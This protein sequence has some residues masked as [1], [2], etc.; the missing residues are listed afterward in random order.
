MPGKARGTRGMPAA[1]ALH[2]RQPAGGWQ[3][4]G[5]PPSLPAGHCQPR[6]GHRRAASWARDQA[7]ARAVQ[8]ARCQ[9]PTVPGPGSHGRRQS[10][11]PACA[12]A[13]GGGD[14]ART[15]DTGRWGAGGARRSAGRAASGCHNK[16]PLCGHP[17]RETK[18]QGKLLSLLCSFS[19]AGRSPALSQPHRLHTKEGLL[20]E[21]GPPWHAGGHPLHCRSH[22]QHGWGAWGRLPAQRCSPPV[23]APLPAPRT[24]R[25]VGGVPCPGC[26][27][28][29]PLPREGLAAEPGGNRARAASTGLP[30]PRRLNP[31]PAGPRRCCP[32]GRSGGPMRPCP[33]A[34]SL[35]QLQ[36]LPLPCGPLPEHPARFAAHSQL[37]RWP[38]KSQ[39]SPPQ[40]TTPGPAAAAPLARRVIPLPELPG[41]SQLSRSPAE[42]PQ[43]SPRLLPPSHHSRFVNS[44]RKV[45]ARSKRGLC[46][47]PA[48]G[49]PRRPSR[50]QDVVPFPPSLNARRAR[51][52]W[53]DPPLLRPLCA[54]VKRWRLAHRPGPR[55]PVCRTPFLVPGDGLNE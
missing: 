27:G 8:R 44:F 48:P 39:Q 53:A 22:G 16:G 6:T 52:A 21:P 31:H 28:P 5:L 47:Q 26:T 51:A 15:Q 54:P 23:R 11:L 34:P 46:P 1:T 13:T 50:K 43:G 7:P 45:P 41:P 2:T 36:R 33:G 25:G 4:A 10:P 35:A 3:S 40:P 49:P 38:S 17:N 24:G 29:L 42:G 19:H 9:C 14:G 37:P 30:A 12:A 32:R 18:Q 55:T 20:K